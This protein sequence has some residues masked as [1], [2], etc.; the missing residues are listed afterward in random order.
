M[1]AMQRDYKLSS[2]SLNSVSAHF[3]NEQV[4]LLLSVLHSLDLFK[5]VIIIYI[6]N[7]VIYLSIAISRPFFYIVHFLGSYNVCMPGIKISNI[8]HPL[9]SIMTRLI[10][11]G[12]KLDCSMIFTYYLAQYFTLEL[13]N[14]C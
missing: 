3:L 6:L 13:E 8:T 10:I 1:Q 14:G 11:M 9:N 7:M 12:L 2:Y 5:L 4:R